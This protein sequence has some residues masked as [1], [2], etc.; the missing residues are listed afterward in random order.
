MKV[1]EN[2]VTFSLV[3]PTYN[4]RMNL[5]R[6]IPML[7]EALDQAGYKFEI[8]IVDDD[9]PDETWKL[10]EEMA[11]EEPR[12]RI[13]RRLNERGLATAVVAGWRQARGHILGVMDGDLQYPPSFLSNLLK[14]I[15]ETPADI[16]VASRYALGASLT[17]WSLLRKAISRGS[18]LIA[19]MALPAKLGRLRDPNAGFFV[20]RRRVIEDV[21]LRPLGYKMLI[22]VLARGHY[23]RV[24]EIPHDYEGRKEGQSKLGLRQYIEFL[25]HL[26]KLSW[27]TGEFRHLLKFCAVGLSGIVVDLGVLWTLT[28]VY[29]TYYLYSAAIAVECAIA[30]NFI[31]NEFWTFAANTPRD[32]GI[33]QRARRFLKFNVIC[34][35][36]ALIH[37]G[38]LWLL[39]DFFGLHYLASALAAIGGAFVWNYCLNVNL[40]WSCPDDEARATRSDKEL[41]PSPLSHSLG[42]KGEKQGD[43][44]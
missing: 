36:G 18:I 13:I 20:L 38:I 7:V 26:A 12:I 40:T 39:T 16:A 10:A 24:I 41:S 2:I 15:V 34:S 21:E 9:S 35:A 17:N 30:N 1:S 6:L 42:R 44:A 8:I 27:D 28:E 25:S 32:I 33:F 22:E 23:G 37:M 4:E 5:P 19:R 11:R 3:I 14:A 29:R 31:W 43:T